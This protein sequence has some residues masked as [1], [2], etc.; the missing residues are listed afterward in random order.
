[1]KFNLL[2]IYLFFSTTIFSQ[3]LTGKV[4][5]IVSMESYSK[6]KIDSISKKLKTKK[7]KMDKWMR[8]VFENTP[9]VNAYLEFS[10]DESLYYVEDKMQNDGKPIFN[11]NRTFAGGDRRYYKNTKTNEY[12]NESNTFGELFLIEINPK[13]WKITQESKKIG[14]YLC[15]KAI[16]IESTN[17]K[18]KPVVW[19]TPEIPVSFGPLKYNGLP[20]LVLLVEMHRRTISASEIIINPKKEIVIKKPTKGKKMTAEEARKR[21]EAFWK[22]IEKQ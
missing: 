15:F 2:L 14:R 7:V 10:N 17:K 21:G 12:F 11:V 3:Q 6:E 13:K 8:D 19:F 20:G 16:D 5:Y 18:I 9:N 4:T 1:M 22:T